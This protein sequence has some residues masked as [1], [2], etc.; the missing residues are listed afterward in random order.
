[1]EQSQSRLALA[2]G[3]PPLDACSTPMGLQATMDSLARRRSTRTSAST[4]HLPVALE[5]GLKA[6]DLVAPFPRGRHVAIDCGLGAGKLLLTQQIARNVAESYDGRV[7]CIGVA[8]DADRATHLQGWGSF[9]ADGRFLAERCAHVIARDTE[10]GSYARAAETGLSLVESL[11]RDGYDVLIYST[12][13][14]R[15][16]KTCSPCFDRRLGTAWTPPSPPATW[17]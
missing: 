15:W 8:D 16:R 2:L 14:S 3:V 11:R 5:T 6:I 4:L 1:M 10:P 9:V 17:A 13:P 7:V 12:V